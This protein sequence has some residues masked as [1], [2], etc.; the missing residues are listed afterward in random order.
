MATKAKVS[1][2]TKK[3][4]A[5][6][7]KKAASPAPAPKGNVGLLAKMGPVTQTFGQKSK[8][9]VFSKGISP[10]HEVAVPVGTALNTPPGDWKVVGAYTAANPKGFI[11]NFEGQGWGNYVR[12]Q[13]TKTGEIIGYNH[14]NSVNVQP[15][16]VVKGGM[17][18]GSSGM[19]GNATGPHVA[20]T[21]RNALGQVG[22]F[23]T[24]P[25]ARYLG[26]GIS[27]SEAGSVAYAPDQGAQD[28]GR[29]ARNTLASASVA[30]PPSY[31]TAPAPPKITASTPVDTSYLPR[32]Q[33][34]EKQT[35]FFPWWKKNPLFS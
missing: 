35:G 19:S 27:P 18:V 24:S 7:A 33:V 32:S 2:P 10:A 25:Y 20:I 31:L 15:G 13:N 5:P 4:S 34:Q 29:E 21:Y 14:M 1:T 17:S 30:K 26:G 16:Q 6:A 23:A 12:L 3:S 11:G 9:D 8:Y 28:G 22:N